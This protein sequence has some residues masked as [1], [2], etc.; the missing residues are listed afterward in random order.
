MRKILIIAKREYRAMVATKAFVITLVLMPI[1]M[2]GGIFFQERLRQRV[3]LDEKRMVVLD[4]TGTLFDAM[5]EAAEARNKT[6]IFDLATGAQIKP[7]YRLERGP[8]GKVTDEE[9]LELSERIRRGEIHAFVEIPE[10]VFAISSSGGGAKAKFYAQNMAF[11]EEKGWLQQSLNGAVRRHRLRE[12]KI[13]PEAVD[14]ASTWVTVEGLGLF[15]KSNDGQSQPAAPKSEKLAFLL[16]FGIMMLMFMVILLASQPMI[17]TVMEER[18]LRIAEVLLGSVS[19][20]QLMAGKLLGC[21]AGSLTIVLA[22]GVGAIALAWYYDVLHLVPLGIVPWFLVY[23]V[24]AVLLFSS[25]FMAVGACVNDRKEAQSMLIPV[26]LLIV[27]PMFIWFSV[28]QQ[29][30]GNFAMWTSFVPPAT[31]LLMVLR[32]T[33]SPDIPLWQPVVGVAILLAATG[34]CVFAAGRIFRIAILSQ[35]QLPKLRQLL[36]WIVT[37]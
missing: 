7:C 22:Y 13:D 23:Q 3:N 16:P 28:L 8:G 36:R 33:A 26:M 31:A 9:R 2:G 24:L 18:S 4:Q 35:G 21:V 19:P 34:L 32:L 20:S 25:L 11:S 29:P 6:A 17:E 14:R 1:L 27:F 15:A 37:G 12:A 30:T 10:D 5:S